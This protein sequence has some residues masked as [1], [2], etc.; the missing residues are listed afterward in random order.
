MWKMIGHTAHSIGEL[1]P[2]WRHLA[3]VA[4]EWGLSPLPDTA[5]DGEWK[6]GEAIPVA[7]DPRKWHIVS[8]GIAGNPIYA[9]PAKE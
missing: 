6:V 1:M 4:D 5:P 2:N 3:G 9:H 8:N 7:D